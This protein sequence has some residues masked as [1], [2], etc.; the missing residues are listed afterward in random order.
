MN[1]L[2]TTWEFLSQPFILLII[3]LTALI[4]ILKQ[5]FR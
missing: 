1:P 5:I 3:G 2:A 4:V